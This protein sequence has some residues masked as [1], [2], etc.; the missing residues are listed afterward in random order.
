MINKQSEYIFKMSD[1]GQTTKK[2][3]IS[4][5]TYTNCIDTII[6]DN[7][8]PE[9]D[10][11]QPK[12][13]LGKFLSE[14]TTEDNERFTEMQ[15]KRLQNQREK[16]AWAQKGLMKP[17][18]FAKPKS[19]HSKKKR[20]RSSNINTANTRLPPGFLSG[21]FS[22]TVYEMQEIPESEQVAA[23]LTE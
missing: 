4:T 11:I 8:F 9:S 14:F 10:E 22:N 3:L 7:Y 12:K 20:K 16:Y 18:S 13:K 2:R 5:G 6:Q 1:L 15:N 19:Q 23:E 21:T 17:T